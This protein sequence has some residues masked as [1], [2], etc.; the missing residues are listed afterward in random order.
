MKKSTLAAQGTA[1]IA[2]L[3]LLTTL[4][5][6]DSVRF[7]DIDSL[8]LDMTDAARLASEA[9]AGKIIEIEMEESNTVWEVDIVNEANLVTTLKIDGQTGEILST[10]SDDDTEI[11]FTTALD[12]AQAI[13]I[14]KAVEQG[15][16]IEAELEY[17]DGAL[18]W[19]IES[20]SDAD[21]ESKFRIDAHTGEI[22]V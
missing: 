1:S 20:I 4:A 10:R 5:Q 21:Q 11:W 22:L 19:E 12:L 6:A 18:V 17:D 15:A 7:S 8:A 14:V 9:N 13:D 16:L 3:A 2:A